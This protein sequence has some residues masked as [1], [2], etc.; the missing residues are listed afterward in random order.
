[1]AFSEDLPELGQVPDN[2]FTGNSRIT[3]GQLSALLNKIA[4]AI[5]YNTSQ[6]LGGAFTRA[7]AFQTNT[8]IGYAGGFYEQAA[9]P[10]DFSAPVSFGV[11]S[12]SVAA[13]FF[14]VTGAT[15][16]TE[17][18]IQVTGNTIDDNGVRVPAAVTEIVIPAGTP[19]NSYIE[20]PEKYNGNVLVE[21]VAGTPISCNYGYSKYHDAGNRDF[22][23]T[24]LE[25]IW[26][27]DSTDSSSDIE[28]IHHKPTGWTYNA[29][30][31]ADP[32]IFAS[33]SGDHGPDNA[34]YVG[35]GA[36]KRANLNLEVNGSGNEGIL[37]RVTSG[38]T[39][40]GALS[41][42]ELDIEISIAFT[43]S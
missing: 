42:R 3:S 14:V 19:A 28:L 22:V 8:P 35:Q 10:S 13:H 24:G 43:S 38:S 4:E 1:M 31:P 26:E 20:T 29:A 21:T 16:S 30:A 37:F 39:G 34:Q 41:F 32:P 12:A 7:W 40:L 18:R 11:A 5:G 36:W 2:Y 17:V 6:P 9:T 27:S 25:T 15:P 23:V 33:R